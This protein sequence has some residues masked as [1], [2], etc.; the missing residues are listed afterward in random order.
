MP[1]LTAPSASVSGVLHQASFLFISSTFKF[2]RKLC[3]TVG[4]SA[5]K[6]SMRDDIKDLVKIQKD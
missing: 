3:L 2:N 1:L 4:Q 5:W 6:E